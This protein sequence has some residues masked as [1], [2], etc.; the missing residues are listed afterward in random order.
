MILMFARNTDIKNG[1]L[2]LLMVFPR[3]LAANAL[4]SGGNQK[5]KEKRNQDSQKKSQETANNM[6]K[7]NEQRVR[8]VDTRKQV[9]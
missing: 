5:K 6:Q 9:V 2:M 4:D 1:M 8:K 3:T 7:C